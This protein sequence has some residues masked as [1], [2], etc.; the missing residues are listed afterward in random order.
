VCRPG[1]ID[2]QDGPG[3]L[4]IDPQASNFACGGCGAG[5]GCATLCRDGECVTSGGCG[6]D[7]PDFCGVSEGELVF[8]ICVDLDT[9]PENCGECG[10][11]CDFDEV[12]VQ[13]DC[14]NF[15]VSRGCDE[16][17]CST[18]TGQFD[19]C[20]TYPGGTGI[21]CLDEEANGCP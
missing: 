2:C 8:G 20:C 4:C 3:N 19:I 5:S 6:G 13:G 16:C 18:C 12:C 9:D 11:D 14:E 21:I 10:N 17:P 15:Q 7:R 1:L